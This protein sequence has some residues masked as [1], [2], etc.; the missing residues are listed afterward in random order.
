[1]NGKHRRIVLSDIGRKGFAGPAEEA[2]AARLSRAA[3]CVGPADLRSRRP[4]RDRSWVRKQNA[5]GRASEARAVFDM[6]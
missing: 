5:A 1:M 6:S 4:V 3:S 2:A